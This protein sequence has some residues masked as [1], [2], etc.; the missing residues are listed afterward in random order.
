MS[1]TM[2]SEKDLDSRWQE[3]IEATAQ[4]FASPDITAWELNALYDAVK[5]GRWMEGV[6]KNGTYRY[7]DRR[8]D[9]ERSWPTRETEHAPPSYAANPIVALNE[10]GPGVLKIILSRKPQETLWQAS[11]DLNAGAYFASAAHPQQCQAL[12]RAVMGAV[13]LRLAFDTEGEDE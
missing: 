1:T 9:S 6:E 4:A 12:A 2:L 13:C 7:K 5:H 8:P 3:V 10:T 11:C